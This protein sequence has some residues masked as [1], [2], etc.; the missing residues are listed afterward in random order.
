VASEPYA[1][2]TPADAERLLADVLLGEPCADPY[3]SYRLLREQAPVLRT[4]GGVLVLSRYDD[5]YDALRRPELGRADEVFSAHAGKLSDDQFRHAMRWWRRTVLFSNPPGHTRL[6]RAISAAFTPHHV[7]RLRASVAA[8]AGET[9]GTLA[10]QPG[11]D[12]V[13]LVALPLP[14]K[15]IAGFLGMPRGDYPAFAPAVRTMVEL[16]EP[17][18]DAMTIARAV[19]AQDELAG[20]FAELLAS[21]RRR[22]G[23]D[24]LTRLASA[25]RDGGLDDTEIIATAILLFAAGFETTTNLLSNGLHALLTHHDQLA[26]LRQRPQLVPAAVEEF[27]RFDPPVQLTSRTSMKSCTVAGVDLPPGRTVLVLIAAANRDPARFTDPDRLDIT[28]D[29]GASL[30]FGTGPHFCLGAH[31]ARLEAAEVF[32]RLLRGFPHLALAGTPRRR[33]GSSLR[34]FAELPVTARR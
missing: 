5:V 19:T 25:R 32:T 34:G 22:P 9:L 15:V 7:E 4:G 10:D 13:Q 33:R 28:R 14:V 29:E 23:E 26:M 11:A 6:R 18:A 17:F 20:Y 3:V 31:L 24:L 21:K 16:F 30:A 2:A 12:F 8:I 1:I 27:L